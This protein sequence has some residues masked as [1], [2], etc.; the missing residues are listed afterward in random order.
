[1]YCYL[2]WLLALAAQA[3]CYTENLGLIRM[4]VAL[5]RFRVANECESAV[6]DAFLNRPGLVDKTPGFIGLEAF[7]DTEDG[8]LFYLITRWTDVNSFR[9]WHSGP[10]HK[11]AHDGIPKGLKLDASFTLVRTLERISGDGALSRPD[12]ARDSAFL[13]SEFL[14]HSSGVLWLKARLDGVIIAR[15]EA[16]QKRL[17][18]PSLDG[19]LIWPLL[20]GPDAAILRQILDSGKREASDRYQLNFVD[21]D[22]VPFT[23]ACH[24]DIQPEWFE[25]IGEPVQEDETQLQRELIRLNNQLAVQLRENGRKTKA[26][27]RAKVKLEQALVELCE[28]QR[29]LTKLQEVIPMCMRCGKVKT[30]ESTWEAVVDYFQ[31]NNL[32]LSHG[33]CPVC[34]EKEMDAL[35]R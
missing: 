31:R 6:R 32:M 4:V 19:A 22:Q 33:Y 35:D 14:H 26:L 13:I 29:H 18:I 21:R 12:G 16:F 23:L 5:S 9:Q 3:G 24:I 15:N 2:K 7:T 28:S 25:M 34:L 30:S 10:D 11:Q 20:T 17:R 27:Q 1:M 8:S